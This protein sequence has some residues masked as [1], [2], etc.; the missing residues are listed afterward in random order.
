VC[1]SCI[2]RSVHIISSWTSIF[3]QHTSWN[4]IVLFSHGIQSNHINL[5]DK[6]QSLVKTESVDHMFCCLLN[7]YFHFHCIVHSC[8]CFFFWWFWLFIYI[9]SSSPNGSSL[10]GERWLCVSQPSNHSHQTNIQRS[11]LTP[12]LV[13]K[14]CPPLVHLIVFYLLSIAPVNPPLGLAFPCRALLS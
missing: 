1:T 5:V 6:V 13:V 8:H 11:M 14:Y 3:K 2:Q 9:C 10:E 7:Y 12:Y 4:N